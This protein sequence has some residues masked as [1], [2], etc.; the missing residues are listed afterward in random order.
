MRGGNLLP[1]V[2]VKVF[3]VGRTLP[4]PVFRY[5]KYQ[6]NPM[7][8][9]RFWLALPWLLASPLFAQQ[10]D[11]DSGNTDSL[12]ELA[13]QYHDSG[14]YA[15]SIQILS[16]VSVSNPEYPAACYETALSLYYSGNAEAAL[17][18]CREAND[19][20]YESSRLPA[21][22]G[23]ILDDLGKPAAGIAV[24]EKAVAVWPYNQNLLYN[25]G[26]CY[27][28]AGYPEK[29]EQ[30]LCRSLLC[31]P[32]HAGT[33]LALARANYAMGRMAQAH[34]A[35]QMAI[36][37]N[38]SLTVIG[39]YENIISGKTDKVSRA[40]RYP[41]APG[42]NHSRWDALNALV[43]SEVAFNDVAKYPYG[44]NYTI[45]REAF[46]LFSN[47]TP[48]D[49]DTT[50]YNRLYAGFF[51]LIKK[52]GFLETYV[53]YIMKNTSDATVGKWISSNGQKIND[54]VEVAKN[55]MNE[56]RKYGFSPERK[57]SATS[58]YQFDDNGDLTSIGNQRDADGQKNG[59]WLVI[60]K[61]G[62]VDEQGYYV[63][64]QPEG[65]YLLYWANGNVRQ[66]LNFKN[67]HL[68]GVCHTYY[69][70]GSREGVYEFR[71]GNKYGHEYTF[72][73]SGLPES[74]YEYRNDTLHG[75]GMVI[76]YEDGFSREFNYSN[77]EPEGTKSETWLN[78]EK[79]MESTYSGG[80]LNGSYT[81]W[82]ANGQKEDR[83]TYTAG[84]RIAG[85]ERYNYNG[86]LQESGVYDDEGGLTG[87]YLAYDNQ[88]RLVTRQEFF[89]K[90]KL[91]G[92]FISYFPDGQKQNVR[93]YR[94]DTL[95]A[96]ES[97]DGKDRLLHKSEQTDHIVKF[98]AYYQDG[99]LYSEGDLKD[100]Q[101]EGT[102]KYYNP[103]GIIYQE[104]NYKGNL[105][106]GPQKT[107]YA[108]G[109]IHERYESDSSNII[110][111][112]HEYYINGNVKAAGRYVKEG[113]EG[114]WLTWYVNDSLESRTFY[115]AGDITGRSFSYAPDGKTSSVECWEGDEKSI[116]YILY[117]HEGLPEADWDY[118]YGSF[119]GTLRFPNGVLHHTARYR[120]NL[121]DSIQ[122]TYFPNGQIAR[123]QEFLHGNIN[124]MVVTWDEAGRLS[125]EYMYVMGKADGM[126]KWYEEGKLISATP[127]E[128][129][130]IQGT[131]T[132]YYDNGKV[133][134]EMEYDRDKQN[135]F[136]DF[137]APDG[138]FMYRL[139]FVD[140]TLKGYTWKNLSGGFEPEK[141]VTR[142][143]TEM[144]CYYPNGR[145]SMRVSLKNGLY[146]GQYRSFYPNGQKFRETEFTD[147]QETKTGRFY[148]LSG[149]TKEEIS[150]LGDERYGSYVLYHE[151]GQKKLEGNYLDGL[152]DGIWHVFD[153]SGKQ[154]DTLF[155]HYG[156]MYDIRKE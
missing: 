4:I 27:L 127:Y 125:G 74:H 102:W 118:Q 54:F 16:A 53:N 155:Y 1:P 112:Y 40:Y 86:T 130:L 58:Y 26:I 47:L 101:Q 31:N 96:V 75:R 137:Y 19:L 66:R 138:T 30:V 149:K 44:P 36:V 89:S 131:S 97:Y 150:F 70:N 113:R 41:Y 56:G 103:L 46:L 67:G 146:H 8:A 79:K 76:F 64:D 110:G 153:A 145:E 11:S 121:R 132:D 17:A 82:Y 111:P 129:G 156:T 122:E 115:N 50:L 51:A 48:D 90:G 49:R 100:G 57:A 84:K 7:N 38:P 20:Q 117:N 91:D 25:L 15:R 77:G 151:N 65:E 18:K 92:V 147:D 152:R 14:A 141:P 39:E 24:L 33:N 45:T 2:A 134:S 12:F 98:R 5:L 107:Y 3:I 142:A 71:N 116:R 22:E 29:A 108:N 139:R 60:N 21:L 81:D 35:Y 126:W 148:Y 140:G 83:F 136:G 85:W 13:R 114:E 69:K 80:E 55:Y 42:Y 106:H 104:L 34:L 43:Q 99:I 128:N 144:V 124:G 87:S 133:R 61:E 59:K 143:T 52:S 9:F 135:G 72:T 62:G 120:D 23:S 95:V 6:R 109:S 123:R 154:K 37:L 10:P 119:T 73:T 28:N 32:Y 78:G 93:T 63:T 105:L 88:G 94:H 68:D